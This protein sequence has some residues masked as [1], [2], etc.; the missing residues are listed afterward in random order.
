MPFWVAYRNLAFSFREFAA[1]ARVLDVGFGE[2][3]EMDDL[4]AAGCEAVGV[5]FSEA[6]VRLGRAR[7]LDVQ[8]APAESL[9]FPDASVDGVVC[10]VVLPY[11]DEAVAIRE[12]ARVLRPG[13][14]VRAS[15]HG[16]GY[17]LRYLLAGESI[18]L[19]IYGARSIVN[20]WV[21][22]LTGRRLPGFVGDTIYQAE[23]RLQRH[24]RAAGLELV[25][26]TEGARYLGLPVFIYHALRRL[27]R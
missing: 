16:V 22:A 13:G 11:T 17:Y 27:P 9:P 7:G 26:R 25:D 14:T 12:W 1:G 4:R 6:S 15:Y 3:L 20:G 5:D 21:Y 19:R 23:S 8:R 24:Y 18:P 10:K 2:G